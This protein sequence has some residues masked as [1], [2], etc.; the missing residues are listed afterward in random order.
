[1]FGYIAVNDAPPLMRNDEEAVENTE[2][3]ES[4]WVPPC[5]SH[6]IPASKLLGSH[7]RGDRGACGF[8]LTGQPAI[9]T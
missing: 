4:Q 6:L 9:T 1:M 2:G 7:Y 5:D 3:D 8:V